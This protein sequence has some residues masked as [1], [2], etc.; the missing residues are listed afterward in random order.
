MQDQVSVDSLCWDGVQT[1][2]SHAQQGL[3]P[4]QQSVPSN[5]P[6]SK[7]QG[8]ALQIQQE[9]ATSQISEASAQAWFQ[10]MSASLDNPASIATQQ[11]D[12]DDS[13]EHPLQEK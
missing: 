9:Q 2:K 3:L 1:I 13:G 7:A 11:S 8:N 6:H 4:S 12:L 10:D 5:S